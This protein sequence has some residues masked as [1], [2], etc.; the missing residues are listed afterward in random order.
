MD[1]G[2][3]ATNAARARKYRGRGMANA[4]AMI[5][6]T[7]GNP[8][9]SRGRRRSAST[10]DVNSARGLSSGLGSDHGES[11]GGAAR[12]GALIDA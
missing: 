12:V 10:Y 4:T 9:T 2:S 7:S 5:A 8:T 1:C 11:G 3:D 6:N